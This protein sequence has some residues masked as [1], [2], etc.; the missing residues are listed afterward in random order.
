[1]LQSIH[2]VK[3]QLLMHCNIQYSNTHSARSGFFWN[4]KRALFAWSANIIKMCPECL[5]INTP[6]ERIIPHKPHVFFAPVGTQSKQR[7]KLHLVWWIKKENISVLRCTPDIVFHL[8][9]FPQ[10]RAHCDR[11]SL[12]GFNLKVHLEMLHLDFFFAS[13]NKT[14]QNIKGIY[15][16]YQPLM[17]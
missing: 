8:S 15:L 6:Q 4:D 16:P 9:P 13:L 11:T 17:C 5:R 1:M 10:H 12:V 2:A 14:N 3:V 7:N